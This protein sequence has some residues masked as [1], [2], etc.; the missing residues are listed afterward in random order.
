MLYERWLKIAREHGNAQALHDLASGRRWTFCQLEKAAEQGGLGDEDVVF[1]CGNSPQF[2]LNV[3]RAWRLDRVVCPLEFGQPQPELCGELPP[4]VIHLKS[5]SA[6]TG[7]SRLVAFRGEQLAADAENIVNTMG[8]RVDWP[9]LGVISLAHSYGFSNLVLPLLLKGIPLVLVEG[10]LPEAV[11]LAAG[12]L[13]DVTLP[14]VPALWRAWHEAGVI[15]EHTRLAISAGAPL[16]LPLEQEVF[17]M[18]GLKIHNFYGS[19]ECGGIAYDETDLPR[20]DAACVG[21]ALQ[22]VQISIGEDGCVE[23]RGESVGETYWPEAVDRLSGG[24]F[25]TSDLGEIIAGRIYLRGRAG[26]QINVA[27][28]KVLPEVIERALLEHE[29]VK[30][31]LVFGVPSSDAE[32]GESI[33]GCLVL[34][35]MLTLE[36]LRDFLI[37]KLPA[38]QVPREWWLVDSLAANHRGKISRADWRARYLSMRAERLDSSASS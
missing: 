29:G 5:T 12:D 10:S 37:H 21:S 16:P 17:A 19:S 36:S 23:V 32:R 24:V 2:I 30:E 3:L 1:P 4:G 8:L 38:W 20:T 33:V 31:C 13:D 26:N 6:S 34:E 22:D 11:R 9:N 28:R 25:R 15:P 18:Q 27:G 35:E 7:A 14:A